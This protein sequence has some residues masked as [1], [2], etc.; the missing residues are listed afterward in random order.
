MINL[1]TK[2]LIAWAAISIACTS[3][4]TA[5]APDGYYDSAK[6]KS[7]QSLLEALEA[8]VGTH[9]N[10]GYNALWNLYKKSD[11]TADGYIWDMYSTAK[12]TPGKNQ[13]GSYSNI[14]DCYNREHSMPKSWF[15]EASPMVSD[16]FHIVPTDGKVNGQRS[17]YP[18]G[19]CASGTTL[20]PNGNIRAL[21]KLGTCTFPGYTG[22]VFEPDDQYKGDFARNYF[23]MA[24]AYNSR[25][26]SWHS[27]MLAGNSY[28][29]FT[30]WAI[31]LLLKWSRQDPVSQKEIDRNNAIYAEQNNRNPFIDHPELIE[32]I[33]GNST[34]T[35]WTPGGVVKPELAEPADGSTADLGLTATGIASTAK[36]PVKGANLTKGLTV[37]VSGN[38]FSAN[39]TAISAEAANAGDTITVTFLSST[40]QDATGTLAIMSDE[41]KATVTLKAST[42]SSIPALA[43]S[44]VTTE[45]FVAHWI[46]TDG[47]NAAY[48]LSVCRAS[49]GTAVDGYPASVSAASQQHTVSGL[50]PNTAYT[51]K[52]SAADGRTSNTIT[53]TTAAPTPI[54]AFTAPE[55][56]FNL[57]CASGEA[58]PV[59]EAGIYAE[60]ID[61][62]ITLSVTGNFEVSLNKTDWAKKLTAD[63]EGEN[64]YLRIADTSTEGEF[65]GVLELSTENYQGEEVDVTA[66][67]GSQAA[68]IETFENAS[69]GGYWSDQ[70][71]TGN[72]CRW[73]MT[74]AGVWGTSDDRPIDMRCVRFGKS[75]TASIAMADDKT[76]GASTVTFRAAPFG[77]DATAEISL[78]YSTDA[79]EQ[80]TLLK[81]F[82]VTASS[83]NGLNEYSCSTG[84]IDG[85][86]RFKWE[87]T[88]TGRR[89]NIDNITITDFYSGVAGID[90]DRSWDAY[91]ADGGITLQPGA[92][93]TPMTIYDMQARTTFAAT[94]SGKRT[95][96]LETGVYVVTAGGKSKKVVV[97]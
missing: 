77:S 75:A 23:Y 83:D 87:R 38:G 2:R 40:A 26:G 62:A 30:Q 53:V 94:V 39:K 47:A 73:A 19:E 15:N 13:C 10:V 69:E 1:S 37:T 67:I 11:V 51:Y 54:L 43:A 60:W 34:G 59:I 55:G 46:N 22:T 89:V 66:K 50:K 52:L 92:K 85:R 9:T 33:W 44:D 84:G 25:I 3:A 8:I 18:Y 17:N 16:A 6:G 93:A 49:D 64:F 86:V 48:T 76:N 21:G 70:T 90:S 80:W 36:I 96:A 81:T 71:I 27:D 58:S 5:Q 14:G 95:V 91:P 4:M 63:N 88:T 82:T 24:A 56:G 57:N 31:N 42:T 32:Y 41:A 97:K 12:F 28:P 79:G 35:G 72:M 68:W 45:S 61:E 20:S 78:Y 7:G 29:A 74:N 65:S